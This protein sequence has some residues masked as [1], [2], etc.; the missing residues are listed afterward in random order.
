MLKSKSVIGFLSITVALSITGCGSTKPVD[1]GAAKG[2]LISG[3]DLSGGSVSLEYAKNYISISNLVAKRANVDGFVYIGVKLKNTGKK[4]V[5][6]I[7][8]SV[9]F[10][11]EAGNIIHDGIVNPLTL[12]YTSSSTKSLKP[13][14]V[15]QLRTEEEFII[16]KVPSEWS[17]KISGKITGVSFE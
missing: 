9:Y 14:Y 16:T 13:G 7:E 4:I 6:D 12:D 8:L 15:R 3:I 10:Y 5:S 1:E 2:E 11:D 17:G